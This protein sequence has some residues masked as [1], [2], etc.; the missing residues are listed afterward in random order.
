MENFKT[1]IVNRLVTSTAVQGL[2]KTDERDNLECYCSDSPPKDEFERQIRG[3]VFEGQVLVYKSLPYAVEIDSIEN[4]EINL[5]EYKITPLKE[6]TCIRVFFH[7][8]KWFI[9]THR[10]LDAYKSKWG[11]ESFGHLFEKSVKYKTNLGVDEF[12][13]HLNKNLSYTFLIGTN[14]ETRIVSPQYDC[15]YVLEC[16]DK[17]HNKVDFYIDDWYLDTLDWYLEEVFFDSLDQLATKVN[18][19]LYPFESEYGFFLSHKTKPIQ[20]K[21]VNPEYRK[22]SQLRNNLPSIQ[23]AY[24]H[25]IFNKDNKETFKMLYP[26]FCKDFDQYDYEIASIVLDLKE[27]YFSRFVKKQQFVVSKEEHNILYH[28]HGIFL[29][30]R[31]PISIE[32]I[33][34]AFKLVPPC[35]LNRIIRA[36]KKVSN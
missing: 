25:N 27:K 2:R 36:R 16:A 5:K 11:K 23:F 24:L 22:L 18:G 3:H 14:E 8:N 7:N 30:N 28:I 15:L 34:E 35:N 13:S 12:L 17:D 31:S 6:G 33:F 32:N 4:F 1:L 9:T 20:Y 10:K 19:M 21:I 29:R 26:K